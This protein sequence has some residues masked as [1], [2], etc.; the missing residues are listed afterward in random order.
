[1]ILNSVASNE[2]AYYHYKIITELELRTLEM[3]LESV[4]PV[5]SPAQSVRTNHSPSSSWPKIVGTN[6]RELFR[7]MFL[8]V[9]IPGPES[10]RPEGCVWGR[11][12][13]AAFLG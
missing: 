1:M 11:T 8:C 6:Q 4:K 10:T 3:V 13:A 9:L 5:K 7:L 2:S 12:R